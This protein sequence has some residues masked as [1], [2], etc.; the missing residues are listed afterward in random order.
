VDE[1]SNSASND[2]NGITT[3][4]ADENSRKPD[5]ASSKSTAEDYDRI[6]VFTRS[7][8]EWSIKAKATFLFIT[9]IAAVVII[10]LRA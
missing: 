4:V 5:L 10:L 8:Q 2:F 7:T 9:S 6:E 1:D 3:E